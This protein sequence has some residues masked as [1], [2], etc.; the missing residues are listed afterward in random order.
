ML[1]REYIAGIILSFMVLEVS[2]LGGYSVRKKLHS[3][4]A[5]KDVKK[6]NSPIKEV[7]IVSKKNRDFE[8]FSTFWPS[9]Q[10]YRPNRVKDDREQ[11]YVLGVDSECDFAGTY[12][13]ILLNESLKNF[14]GKGILTLEYVICGELEP[15]RIIFPLLVKKVADDRQIFLRLEPSRQFKKKIVAWNVTLQN[16]GKMHM[17]SNLFW[18]KLMR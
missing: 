15:R 1:Q 14:M 13:V 9:C 18:K 2:S 10:P 12:A 16:N 11:R 4:S 7:V 3:S 5:K 8:Y 17:Q 6:E